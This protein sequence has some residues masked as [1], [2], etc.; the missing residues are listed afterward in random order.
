[1]LLRPSGKNVMRCG[2][3]RISCPNC[4]VL[5]DVP[6]T[7]LGGGGRRLRCGQCGHGWHFMPEGAVPAAA[8]PEQPPAEQQEP[9]P[10]VE[11]DEVLSRRFGQPIDYEAKAE[12]QAALRDEA[13]THPHPA[14]LPLEP[15]AATET[16]GFADLVRAARNN[17]MD[18]EPDRVPRRR[19]KASPRLIAPLLILLILAVILLDRHALMRAIPASAKLFHALHLS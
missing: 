6:D 18:L 3:M 16:D 2:A 10:A 4:Q 9:F 19:P 5:Y 1:M 17:E 15:S 14:A 13:L 7:L 11:A 8:T 12:V